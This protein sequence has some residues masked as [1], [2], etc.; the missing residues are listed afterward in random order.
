MDHIYNSITSF[1]KTNIFRAVLGSMTKLRGRYR[2][3]P[4]PLPLHTPAP[5]DAQPPDY[6]HTPTRM[7]SCHSDGPLLTHHYH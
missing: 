6:Q 4:T 3:F 2:D 5:T 1:L 7:Y